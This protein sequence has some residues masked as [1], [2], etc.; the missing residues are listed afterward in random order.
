LTTLVTRLMA[1]TWSL[2]ELEFAS[3]FRRIESVSRSVRLDIP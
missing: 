1:T 2:S 3:L